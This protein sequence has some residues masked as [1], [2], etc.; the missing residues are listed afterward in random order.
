MVKMYLYLLVQP[1]S[2]RD[3]Y[4]QFRWYRAASNLFIRHLSNRSQLPIQNSYRSNNSKF[5]ILS[6]T[7][8]NH[9]SNEKSKQWTP[10]IVLIIPNFKFYRKPFKIIVQM[11]NQKLAHNN[12]RHELF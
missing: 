4:E 7:F 6:K 11:K 9:S 5:Q 12:G 3:L 1:S 2:I 10:R 8:Q